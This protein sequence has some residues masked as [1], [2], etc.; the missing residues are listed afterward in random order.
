MRNPRQYRSP[1]YPVH[2]RCARCGED[3]T[4]NVN[5]HHDLSLLDDPTEDGGA[6]ISRK[7]LVGSGRCFQRVHLTLYFDQNRKLVAHEAV[8]GELVSHG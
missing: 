8:G 7:V 5:L 4:A 6:Y 1:L 3:I 2:V